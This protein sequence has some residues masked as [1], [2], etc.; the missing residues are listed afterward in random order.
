MDHALSA[1]SRWAAD[2]FN[3]NVIDETRRVTIRD[4]VWSFSRTDHPVETLAA[5]IDCA[6][7]SVAYTSDTGP[8]WGVAELG[9]GIDLVLYDASHLRDCEGRGIPHSSARE[10]GNEQR[11][12]MSVV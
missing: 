5:R 8:A 3:W 6:G 9:Q 1:G 11:S 10:A 4:Q 7:A 12:Q 2:P